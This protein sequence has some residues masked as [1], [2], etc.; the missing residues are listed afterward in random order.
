[1]SKLTVSPCGLIVHPDHPHLAAS[2]DGLVGL[3]AVVEVKCPAKGKDAEA[4]P[5]N[6]FP[7]LEYRHGK[8]ALKKSHNYYDQVQG[9]LLLSERRKCYFL[10][11]TFVSL[12]VI[13]IEYDPEYCHSSLLPKLNAFYDN[14]FLK[15]IAGTL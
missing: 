8:I 4:K 3:D 11:Y 12:K 13:Q 7:F 14:F 6:A 9:Q 10:V 1:M 5:G 2:P 15:Y